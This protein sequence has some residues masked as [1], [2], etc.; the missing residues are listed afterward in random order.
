MLR[1]WNFVPRSLTEGNASPAV[2]LGF[3]LR[4][5]DGYSISFAVTAYSR[6]ASQMAKD[7]QR[8]S[9]GEGGLSLRRWRRQVAPAVFLL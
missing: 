4:G 5:N 9:L 6:S 7:D 3:R 8:K 1:R 2:H